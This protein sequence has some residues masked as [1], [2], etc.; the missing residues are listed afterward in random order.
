[1]CTCSSC[2]NLDRPSG[3][4]ILQLDSMH[5]YALVL[6]CCCSAAT[7]SY[8]VDWFA[9][10]IRLHVLDTLVQLCH[11]GGSSANVVLAGQLC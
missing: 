5:A 11:V 6:R 4:C 8:I 1:M 7:T 9:F 3:A 2:G 10:T